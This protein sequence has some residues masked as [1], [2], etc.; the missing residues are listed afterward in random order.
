LAVGRNE[1]TLVL[2]SDRSPETIIWLEEVAARQPQ[3]RSIRE[4][5]RASNEANNPGLFR[6]AAKMATG[7]G[8]TCLMPA[9]WEIAGTA[10]FFPFRRR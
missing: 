1:A 5:L 6:I 7:S 4:Q 9:G 2:L 8:K 10:S 3:H